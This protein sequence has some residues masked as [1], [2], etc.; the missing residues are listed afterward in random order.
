MAT[1]RSTRK[2]KLAYFYDHED[3]DVKD[4][5]YGAQKD[6]C[7]RLCKRDGAYRDESISGDWTP[8]QD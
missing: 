5:A 8:D 4:L 1:K 7:K 2:K 3:Q 6:G